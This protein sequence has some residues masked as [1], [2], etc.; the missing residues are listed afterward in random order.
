[1]STYQGAAQA[2]KDLP[3]PANIAAAATVVASGIAQ[4]NAIRSTSPG[5]GGGSVA[6]SSAATLPTGG[7]SSLPATTTGTATEQPTAKVVY[8]N[9]TAD[10]QPL[11]DDDLVRYSNIRQLVEAINDEAGNNVRIYA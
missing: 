9:M 6:I 8:L 10:G 2:L 7:E 5:G 3:F 4:V 11:R 1:M